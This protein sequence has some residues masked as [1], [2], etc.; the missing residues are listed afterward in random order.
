ME[1]VPFHLPGEQS[2][3]F[4]EDDYLDIKE[5]GAYILLLVYHHGKAF[6]ISS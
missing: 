1:Q 2:A 4:Y 6:L 5:V 3:A